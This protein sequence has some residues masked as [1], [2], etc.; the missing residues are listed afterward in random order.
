MY[1]IMTQDQK[2]IVKGKSRKYLCGINEKTRKEIV[3]YKT[4]QNANAA[5]MRMMLIPSDLVLAECG[6]GKVFRLVPVL[7]EGAY[8]L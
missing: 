3:T 8:E 4:E 2:Y 7:R 1:V 5:I 6:D